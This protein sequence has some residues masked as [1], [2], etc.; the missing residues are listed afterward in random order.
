MSKPGGISNALVWPFLLPGNIACDALHLD[1]GNNLIRM[2]V[3]WLV[4][5]A[6]GV[7]GVAIAV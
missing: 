5:T 1:P 6:L 4:W 3:N 2:L 7:V